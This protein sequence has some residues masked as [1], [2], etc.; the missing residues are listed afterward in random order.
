MSEALVTGEQVRE[1]MMSANITRVDHHPCGI[2][3]FMVHYFREGDLLYF[4]PG[5]SCVAGNGPELRPW[6]DAAAWIN[7]QSK[8]EWRDKLRK[9]FGLPQ[10]ETDR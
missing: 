5:C 6:D 1:A 2:C 4:D 8:D 9:Q 10:P 7:M 3:G